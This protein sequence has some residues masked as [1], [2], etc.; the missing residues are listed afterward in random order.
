MNQVAD[1]RLYPKQIIRTGFYIALLTSVITLVTFTMAFLTPPLSGSFCRG[2]C[3]EYPY[4]DIA[5][6][7]P[8]DYY[9]MSLSIIVSMFYLFL[10]VVIH[11]LASQDKRFYSQAGL[12]M[13]FI[14]AAIMIPLYFTQVTVIQPSL[15]N[16]EF[17]G[18]ALWSQFNPHG[19][20]IALEEIS[21]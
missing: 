11:Y 20:F 15:L 7:F 6:R 8:R 16:K 4:T 19:M 9:W 21:Y 17:E 1:S 14:S 12:A 3:F 18:L 10:M 5:E 13:A 2:E